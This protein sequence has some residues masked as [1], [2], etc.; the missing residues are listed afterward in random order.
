MARA[1]NGGEL[2]VTPPRERHPCR[3]TRKSPRTAGT[4]ECVG[5]TGPCHRSRPGPAAACA[6]SGFPAG[7]YRSPARPAPGSR[8]RSGA[9]RRARATAA[10]PS[11]TSRP[12]PGRLLQTGKFQD[13]TDPA[14]GQSSQRGQR[15]QALPTGS[16]G[17][18][19]ARLDQLSS[20]FHQREP[21]GPA[22]GPRQGCQPAR[23]PPGH[24]VRPAVVRAGPRPAGRAHR[25]TWTRNA[26]GY[27]RVPPLLLGDRPTPHRSSPSLWCN[28]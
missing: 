21:L 20:G 12:A 5:A 22:A 17:M 28:W 7:P 15:P 14:S 13:L 3:P 23:C 18:G 9:P 16:A 8:D 19:P 10:C 25:R 27:A 11:N 6:T 1:R 4:L 2:P 24:R 26:L